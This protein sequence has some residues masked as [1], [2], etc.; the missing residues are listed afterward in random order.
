[1]RRALARNPGI[2]IGLAEFDALHAYTLCLNDRMI[3]ES[4]NHAIVSKFDVCASPIALVQRRT[5]PLVVRA[6]AGANFT[7]RAG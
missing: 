6:V 5:L 3:A 2:K 7:G 4:S 1:L